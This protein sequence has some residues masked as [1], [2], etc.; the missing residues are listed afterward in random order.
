MPDSTQQELIARLR[1]ALELPPEYASDQ[2]ILAATQGTILHARAELG[3]AVQAA[4]IALRAAL[5]YIIDRVT[6]RALAA[7]ARRPRVTHAKD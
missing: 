7:H 2:E 1:A 3:I 6:Q 5:I 4:P